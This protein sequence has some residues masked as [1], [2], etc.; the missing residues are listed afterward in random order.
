MIMKKE[1][2]DKAELEIVKITAMEIMNSPVI[3]PEDEEGQD[4]LP[5][6]PNKP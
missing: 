3:D 1:I 4:T 2:Y 5:F 6:V